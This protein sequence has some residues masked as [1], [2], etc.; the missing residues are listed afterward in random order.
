MDWAAYQADLA[1]IWPEIILTFTLL[2]AL[3]TDLLLRGREVRF[4]G[5]VALL[6]TLLA[7]WYVFQGAEAAGDG[8]RAFGLLVHDPFAVFF[9]LLLGIGLVVV[10]VLSMFFR[11]LERD[12]VGEYYAIMLTA[13]LAGFLLV[14][15]D[16]L[17]MLYLALETLS[18]ASYVLAGVLKREKRSSEAALK[19][20]VYGALSS[21]AM[22]YGF[23]LLYGLTG[24]L[25]LGAIGEAVEGLLAD[26]TPESS[27]GVAI[28]L[29]LVLAGFGYK[30]A[31]FPFHFWAPDVY[32]GAP[33]PVTTFLA[34]ISKAASFGMLLRFF[35]A[36]PVLE[37]Q[38][39]TLILAQL[40]A[41]F[42]AMS[43]TFGNIAAMLQDNAKRLLAYSAIA[44]TGYLLMG[45]AAMLTP[46]GLGM[47]DPLLGGS[48][49]GGQAVAFYLTAY[50]LMN[51]PQA[52]V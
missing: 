4:T 14:S 24:Q 25:Q 6:G 33:T 17:L 42:A 32:E 46:G 13:V 31:V 27:I 47:E 8:Q 44:H 12:G 39:T 23:S 18:I 20:L 21:G 35:G 30:I 3:V 43:M 28:S 36:L 1:T 11:G 9:K 16:H 45:I 34:V 26:G 49:T 38:D 7:L 51:P 22:V 48:M 15:T 2:L 19:Y 10:L 29:V 5:W 37:G 41:I 40:L 50:L 52:V